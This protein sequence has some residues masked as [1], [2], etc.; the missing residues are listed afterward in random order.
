LRTLVFAALGAFGGLIIVNF[1]FLR[2]SNLAT[3]EAAG[4]IV[5][6]LIGGSLGGVVLSKF[7]SR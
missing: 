5:G 4:Y 7:N 1:V 3:P 2:G 6:G